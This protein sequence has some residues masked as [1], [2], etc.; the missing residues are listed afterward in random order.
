MNYTV[1]IIRNTKPIWTFRFRLFNAISFNIFTHNVV[2]CNHIWV[3]SIIDHNLIFSVIL[4]YKCY[5]IFAIEC[6][7]NI[8]NTFIYCF[9]FCFHGHIFKHVG[10]FSEPIVSC[11]FLSHLFNFNYWFWNRFD[12][13][14]TCQAN[15]RISRIFPVFLQFILSNFCLCLFST[16]WAKILFIISS[17]PSINTQSWHLYFRSS[18]ITIIKTCNLVYL[19]ISVIISFVSIVI[20]SKPYFFI[21]L[22]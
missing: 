10:K 3:V 14:T 9:E 18:I 1:I 17:S 15:E 7:H 4:F 19:T 22:T 21:W 6:D 13:F 12:L 20:I 5:N 2:I 8:Y 16:T 11:T